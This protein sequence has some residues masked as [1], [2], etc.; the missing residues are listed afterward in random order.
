MPQVFHEDPPADIAAANAEFIREY[1]R[2]AKLAADAPDIHIIMSDRRLDDP[3][4]NTVNV[5]PVPRVPSNPTFNKFSFSAPLG[6]HN[7]FIPQTNT[8]PAIPTHRNLGGH[9]AGHLAGHHVARPRHSFA[10]TPVTPWKGPFADTVPAGVN[11]LPKPAQDTPEVRAAKAAHFAALNAA[12]ASAP[13]NVR[14]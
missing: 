5:N 11:G 9:L 4:F 7:Q 8:F 14:V 12:F 2:L 3:R 13:R 1:N 10:H 6:G